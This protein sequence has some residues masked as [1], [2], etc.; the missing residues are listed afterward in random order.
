MAL[1]AL[2]AHQTA[3]RYWLAPE[4]ESV[5]FLLGQMLKRQASLHYLTGRQK[6]LMIADMHTDFGCLRSERQH[7]A[8][9]AA[10]VLLAAVQRAYGELMGRS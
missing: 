9:H 3:A 1:K 10:E 2:S 7:M 4:G 8:L 5:V 6:P